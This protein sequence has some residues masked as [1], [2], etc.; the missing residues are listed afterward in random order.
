MSQSS[1]QSSPVIPELFVSIGIFRHCPGCLNNTTDLSGCLVLLQV[2]LSW[3]P[4]FLWPL[5]MLVI[6]HSALYSCNS[7]NLISIYPAHLQNS[8]TLLTTYQLAALPRLFKMVFWACNMITSTPQFRIWT[9][10]S[11][12]S[13][14]FNN[15]WVH[16]MSLLWQVPHH[17]LLDHLFPTSKDTMM[18]LRRFMSWMP[19]WMVWKNSSDPTP[20]N[21]RIFMTPV[22]HTLP[23]V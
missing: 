18:I 5:H 11:T 21:V 23:V 1:T 6:H 4:A 7:W 12:I 22:S 13:N 15:I 2:K 20:T 3:A 19:L 10:W 14:H 16:L 8:V 17:R 9:N